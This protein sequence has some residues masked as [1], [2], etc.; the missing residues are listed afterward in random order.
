MKSL[1]FFLHLCRILFRS[2]PER[3]AAELDEWKKI[4]KLRSYL[5]YGETLISLIIFRTTFG[6]HVESTVVGPRISESLVLLPL[7]QPYNM[8]DSKLPK[9]S[10][11]HRN[12]P[13]LPSTTSK[14][15]TNRENLLFASFLEVY[16]GVCV[17]NVRLRNKSL[18]FAFLYEGFWRFEVFLDGFC[19]W[20][21]EENLDSGIV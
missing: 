10:L 11:N 19:L 21:L 2:F 7:L 1:F 17:Q 18:P 20:E 4:C 8:S 6:G 3:I 14:V 13:C 9:Y 15:V 12:P 16:S 5:C